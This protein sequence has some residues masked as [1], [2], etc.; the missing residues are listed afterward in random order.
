M[1]ITKKIYWQHAMKG[2]TIIGL[3]LIAMRLLRMLITPAGFLG[4][5]FGL[6]N[7]CLF[8]YLVYYFTKKISRIADPM[9]GF[10]Y[11]RCIGF[12]VCMML[13]VGFLMGVF[14][15]IN[16]NFINPDIVETSIEISMGMVQDMIPYN[17]VDN[18]YDMMNKMMRSPFYLILYN[19]IAYVI[20]GAIVGLVT[21]A[22]AKR[23]PSIFDANDEE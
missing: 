6:V 2:G 18:Y 14:A 13:F 5:L 11:G 8:V 3:A 23:D 22:F 9:E 21:G 7:L 1:E 20:Y 15:Y 12:S 10:S 19:I 4:T 17:E 16:N